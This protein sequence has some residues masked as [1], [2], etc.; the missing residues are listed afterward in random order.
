MVATRVTGSNNPETKNQVWPLFLCSPINPCPGIS[1]SLRFHIT[2][3]RNCY[4]FKLLS[5]I[6]NRKLLNLDKVEPSTLK[7]K[8][9]GIFGISTEKQI[10]LV[11]TPSNLSMSFS[12]CASSGK[13]L[14]PESFMEIWI[15]VLPFNKCR[16]DY[17]CNAL[18]PFL[19]DKNALLSIVS[20][21]VISLVTLFCKHIRKYRSTM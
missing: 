18:G 17:H 12:T 1:L 5:L 6:G 2:S 14:P 10:L 21:D 11:V 9:F 15:S 3:S 7:W 19:F 20:D 13:I 4:H 16:P 8:P